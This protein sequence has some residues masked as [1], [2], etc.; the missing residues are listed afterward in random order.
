MNASITFG[1]LFAVV[2]VIGSSSG[3][4]SVSGPKTAVIVTT[5]NLQPVGYEEA[6][7]GRITAIHKIDLRARVN[8]FITEVGFEEGAQV[9]QGTVLFEIEPDAYE[10]A[11]TQVEGQ[12]T[13]AQAQQELAEIDFAR[14]KQLVAQ[15]AEAE[16]TL[17]RAEAALGNVNG[18]IE[19]LRG[20]LQKAQ[21]DLSYA[22]ISAPFAGRIGFTDISIGAYVG[23]DSGALSSLSSIDPIYV[24]FPVPEA[25]LI[26]V[27]KRLAG[28]AGGK[29]TI[30]DERSSFQA[31][32]TLANGDAYPHVGKIA[33]IDTEVQTGTDT[34]LVRAK[35]DN[36]DGLLRDGQ[37]VT[38]DTVDAVAETALAIP[39]KALQ[40]DQGGFFVMTVNDSGE[41]AKTAIKVARYSGL[42]VVIASGLSDGQQVITE[43]IQKV[44]PG[45]VVTVHSDGASTKTD[46]QS[47]DVSAE[48]QPGDAAPS[49]AK[50]ATE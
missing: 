15:Q 45:M 26:D 16:V 42:K 24:T 36:P 32:I 35:F 21:L 13:S 17:Q 40:R 46:P 43:G 48:K 14:Q 31:R 1:L 3:A 29:E 25:T 7:T 20:A 37:L 4:Q 28:K 49:D 39:A 19:Q 33:V 6:Y 50:P 34:I 5:V 8:G 2:T 41:V 11:V 22:K 18:R 44:R 23:P 38:I 12:I 10:A 27:R 47:D 9:E 30:E